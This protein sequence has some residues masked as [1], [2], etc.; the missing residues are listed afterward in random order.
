MTDEEQVLARSYIAAIQAFCVQL[1]GIVFGEAAACEH[2]PSMLTKKSSMTMGKGGMELVC[3]CG[4]E[5]T[6]SWAEWKA[7]QGTSEQE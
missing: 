3:E 5:V 6:K 4:A 1:E 2:P 7:M